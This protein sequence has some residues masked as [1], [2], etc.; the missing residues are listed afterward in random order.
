MFFSLRPR[1]ER[2]LGVPVRYLQ[3]EAG[4]YGSAGGLH[5]FKDIILEGNPEFVFVLNCDVCSDY[6]LDELLASHRRNP[7]AKATMLVKEVDAETAKEHGEVVLDPDPTRG[8]QV[9]HYAEKPSSLVSRVVNCGIY[10]FSAKTGIFDEIEAILG[11]AADAESQGFHD[12]LQLMS[13]TTR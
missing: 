13:S 9:L 1:T 2:E 5:R 8:G 12:D 6:P 11:S 10:V 7:E 4:G 3:E